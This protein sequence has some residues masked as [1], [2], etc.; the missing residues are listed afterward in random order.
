MR[1]TVAEAESAFGNQAFEPIEGPIGQC[2]LTGR[3]VVTN[4]RLPNI[5]A[6]GSSEDAGELYIRGRAAP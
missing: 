1:M 2:R 5:A 4:A 3:I 6:E